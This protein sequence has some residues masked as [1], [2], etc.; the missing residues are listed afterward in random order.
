M[1]ELPD[2]VVYV[3]CL[4]RQV[5]GK[6]LKRA[7]NVHPFLVRTFEPAMSEVEG[8]NIRKLRRL[9][10]RIVFELEGE[11]FLV[12]HLMIAGR[13]LWKEANAKLSGKLG[14][15]A[16]DFDSGTLILTEAGT[17]RRASLHLVRGEKALNDHQ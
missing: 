5:A 6:V 10:K 14:L 15:A 11:L 9:G 12:L 16:F 1:P 13:L 4:Q 7:R 17:K 2:I 3:E 8:K